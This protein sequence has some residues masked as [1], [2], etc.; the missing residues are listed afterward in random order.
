MVGK[1][2]TKEQLITELTELRR[3]YHELQ[4][5]LE[6]TKRP[7]NAVPVK[8]DLL[9][10]LNESIPIV[11]VVRSRPDGIVD[12]MSPS[13]KALAGYEPSWFIGNTIPEKYPW[14]F[15]PDDYQIPTERLRREIGGGER[16]PTLLKYRIRT[17]AGD[18]KWI[19][20]YALPIYRGDRLAEILGI[21]SEAPDVG[22]QIRIQSP[23]DYSFTFDDLVGKDPGF[24]KCLEDLRIAANSDRSILITGESGT[25]K[26]MC[27]QAA[28]NHSKR[29]DSPFIPINC[30][31]IPKEL[32]ESELFGY[33]EG[34]FSGARK[35]GNPGKFELADGG[36][37]FLD[38]IESM[39][40]EMQPKLLRVL[41]E[42]R[43]WRLGGKKPK[44][45][46]VRLIAAS[47]IDLEQSIREGSF[48]A[49]LFY[50]IN[51]VSVK[52]P[53]L[54]ERGGDIA[55]LAKHLIKKYIHSLEDIDT[56]LPPR[57]LEEVQSYEWPGNVRELSNWVERLLTFERRAIHAASQAGMSSKE[58]DTGK[59]DEIPPLASVGVMKLSEAQALCIREAISRNKGNLSRAAADLEISRATLYRKMCKLK[60]PKSKGTAEEAI[61][62]SRRGIPGLHALRTQKLKEAECVC[63]RSAL[64]KNSGNLRR[65]AADLGIARETLYRKISDF[66][67]AVV[68]ATPKSSD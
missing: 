50:R 6:Q 57:L 63:I 35:G 43:V 24:R 54:R 11:T 15:H 9:S 26:E 4:S 12:Y 44:P 39:P 59:F 67:I 41:E 8:E 10:I 23:A 32:F 60:I 17:K 18:M 22:G 66:D 7:S 62:T 46:D 3:E 65:A 14:I 31:A 19:C 42:K 68:K 21:L 64:S 36:T 37:L 45:L 30:A 2:K 29:G 40:L 34:A 51:V 47:N 58:R 16:I 1:N 27:A 52:I 13:I 55:L 38:Q 48:R 61:L 28:H 53:P 20:H 33:V 25:G 56:Y 5:E 49:D